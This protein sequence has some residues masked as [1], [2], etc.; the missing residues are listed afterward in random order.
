MASDRIQGVSSRNKV[1]IRNMTPIPVETIDVDTEC[2]LFC[3]TLDS[4][5]CSERCQIKILSEVLN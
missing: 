3:E 5:N 4:C 1:S 2:L